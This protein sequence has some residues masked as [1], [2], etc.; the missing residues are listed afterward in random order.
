MR[1]NLED[2]PLSMPSVQSIAATIAK[3]L[4]EGRSAST[5]LPCNRYEWLA[6][7]PLSGASPRYS[8]TAPLLALVAMRA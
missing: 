5:L 4:R 1:A 7:D 3:D 8:N 2:L 6:K